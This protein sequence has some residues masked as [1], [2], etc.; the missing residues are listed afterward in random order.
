MDVYVHQRNLTTVEQFL[1]GFGISFR[2][3]INDVQAEVD[4]QNRKLARAGGFRYD[5]YNRLS[6][7]GFRWE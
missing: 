7:V 5:N 4:Q 6:T 1:K 3:M 2:S